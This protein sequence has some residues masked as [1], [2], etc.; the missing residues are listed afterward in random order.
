MSSESDLDAKR[1]ELEEL[2]ERV[3]ELEHEIKEERPQERWVAREYYSAY[4]M[5]TGVF[6]GM[7]AAMTSLVFNVVGSALVDQHPLRIIQ[8]YLTFP[9]GEKALTPEFEG[10]IVLTIGCCLYIAT[11]G[12]LGI[13]FNLILTRFTANTTLITRLIVSS[14]VGIAIWI[15]NFYAVLSWLQPLLFGGNW[16]VEQIPWWVGM[17]THLVFGWTMALLYP[18][19][20]YT[21]YKLQ[22]E[23]S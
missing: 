17:L 7:L 15:I 4:Y 12:V 18:L 21:P 22:T 20:L 1:K 9:L 14:A 8:V 11:G 5:T 6:L 10:G 3:S 19:G 16:I 13:P 2:Q 23:Y